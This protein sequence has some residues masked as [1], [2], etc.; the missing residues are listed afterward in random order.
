MLQCLEVGCLSNH[1][2]SIIRRKKFYSFILFFSFFS[3]SSSLSDLERLI[4][5]FFLLLDLSFAL[6][7]SAHTKIEHF[8][9]KELDRHEI[10]AEQIDL[11]FQVLGLEKYKEGDEINI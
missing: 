4:F 1:L 3:G 8:Y 6:G 9:I 10:D 7:C 2:F 11:G 5:D